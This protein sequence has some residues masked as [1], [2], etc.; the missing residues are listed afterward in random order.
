MTTRE[1][2]RKCVACGTKQDRN[3]LI[4]ILQD[5]SNN[6]FIVQPSNQQFGRS[7]YLCN[8]AEC[9]TKIRKHKKYKDKINFDLQTQVNSEKI[10]YD[11]RW[12]N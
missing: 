8:N 5:Y 10:K 7:I 11:S 3:N 9:I 4:R 1:I 12:K 6:E 2:V